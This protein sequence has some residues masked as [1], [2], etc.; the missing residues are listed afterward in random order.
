VRD[1]EG[2]NIAT[3]DLEAMAGDRSYKG[4]KITIKLPD[5][6]TAET[7][8][9][10]AQQQRLA[11][12]LIEGYPE[13]DGFDGISFIHYVMGVYYEWNQFDREAWAYGPFDAARN[14]PCRWATTSPA[15]GTG[16]PSFRR[17]RRSTSARATT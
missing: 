7:K 15:V 16:P 10:D 5:G 9:T 12:M 6:R 11:R 13:D 4:F 1:A 17:K 8:L 2:R 14:A 3:V